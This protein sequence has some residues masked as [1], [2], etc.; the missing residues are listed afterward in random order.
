MD[1]QS[2]WDGVYS[3]KPPEQLSWFQPTP[4]PSLSFVRVLNL[5]KD[6]PII[7]VGAGTSGL[8]DALLDDGYTRLTCL[9]ASAEARERVARRLGPERF[10]QVEWIVADIRTWR[11]KP[12]AYA[13]WHDR[14]MLHFLTEEA[15]RKA[16]VRAASEGVRK[17]GCVLVGAFAS[18]GGPTRCSGLTVRRYDDETIAEMFGRGFR[19]LGSRIDEHM[20][21]WGAPQRFG[22]F[23]LSRRDPVDRPRIMVGSPEWHERLK[24]LKPMSPEESAQ[25]E[26]AVKRLLAQRSDQPD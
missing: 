15:D 10:A 4:E 14:A 19:L 7:D 2:H 3:A 25:L 11:P 20:T 1:T 13:L 12:S 9:D 23:G 16:Y 8:V 18:E 22:W 5:G 17:G 6:E 24:N 26:R 21:P